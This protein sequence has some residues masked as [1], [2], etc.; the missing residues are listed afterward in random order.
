MVCKLDSLLWSFLR[1]RNLTSQ[2]H[3]PSLLPP[4]VRNTIA[5]RSLVQSLDLLHKAFVDYISETVSIPTEF[6]QSGAL[7]VHSEYTQDT[8]KFTLSLHLLLPCLL[9]NIENPLNLSLFG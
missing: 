7:G 6:S 4:P 1:E 5:Q 2:C 3:I 8:V 9:M